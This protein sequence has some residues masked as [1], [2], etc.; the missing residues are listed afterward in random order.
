MNNTI[1]KGYKI[2]FTTKTIVM[3]YK[4]SAASEQYGTPEYNML[5]SIKADFPTFNIITKAGRNITTP[6]RTKRMTYANMETYIKVFDNAEE[7]LQIFNRAKAMS[8]VLKSP[9]KFVYDWFITQ[10]PKYKEVPTR[11]ALKLTIM[12]KDVPNIE[13]YEEKAS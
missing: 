9:Y 5:K 8:K 11:T 1:I 13:N 3:N 7:L 6:R 2:D 10:F 12:P 4:F